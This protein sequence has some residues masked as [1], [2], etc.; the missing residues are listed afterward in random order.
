M[1]GIGNRVL[2]KT[3]QKKSYKILDALLTSGDSNATTTAFIEAHFQLV[4]TS[5]VSALGD[6]NAAAKVPRLKCLLHLMDYVKSVEQQIFLRQILPEVIL[7]LKEINFKSREA[8]AALLASM[9][10]R[11]Q[12]VTAD[13]ATPEVDSLGEFMRLVM[14]GLAGSGNMAACT[15]LALASLALEFREHVTGPLISELVEAACLLSK[16]EHKEVV[17][18]SLTLLKV[19]CGIFAQSTLAQYLTRICQTILG[20]HEKRSGGVADTDSQNKH[21]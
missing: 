19:V 4:A 15:C 5:F 8:S 18:A 10:R 20:L 1:K 16:S 14:V 9:L 7:C 11:W 3:L 2:D 13:A 17:I 21:G 12:K 6:C